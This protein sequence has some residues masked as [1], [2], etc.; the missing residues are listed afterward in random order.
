MP[1]RIIDAFDRT[2]AARAEHPALY[3][4]RN[5][6]W[7]PTTWR[8]YRQ[9]VRLA[10][11]ALIALG[12]EPG[13][14][15]TIIGFNSA[16][17]FIADIGAIAAGAIPAGIYTTNTPDQ[18]Q[19]IAE[20]CEA[21]VAFVENAEQ[22]A[23]FR[24]VRDQLPHLTTIVMM[25]AEPESD[26]GAISWRQFLGLGTGVP[27]EKLE[28]RIAAQKP[29]DTCTL[30]YTSGTT[31]VPKAVMLSHTN[32]VWVTETA[33][34]IVNIK[35]GDVVVS[36][37]PLSHVAEQLF[38]LHN[39]VVLG[40][41]IWFAESLDKLGDALKA[42]RPHHFL[43]VPR[44]WEK[45]QAK[46]E[47]V[48]GKNSPIK[49]KIAKWAREQGLAGG[50][51]DQAGAARPMLYGIADKLVFSK[52]RQNIGLDRART[53]VTGAAP[54]SKRTLDFFLSLGLPISEV[55]GMS[56]TT[57][58]GT[59]SHPGK[60]RTGKAGYVMPGVEMR[61]AEDGEICMRGKHIAKGYF[62]DPQATAE[63]IDTDG[64]LH[65]GDIGELDA[66]GFLQITDRKK[67]LIITAGGENIAPAL[68]EGQIKSIGVVSQ[69]V[70]IGDRRRYLSVLLTLDPEKLPAFATLA[71]SAAKNPQEAAECAR[72]SAYLQRE[73]EG[74]NT[75]LARVQTVKKFAV[76]PTELSIDGGE[77]T[78]TMKIKRK[79]VS[80]KYA[81]V[82][83]SLYTEA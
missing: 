20:H 4:R 77:L 24:A 16:E 35:A 75:R 50:Y 68:V 23:K 64:W 54:I 12:V 27:E 70:V 55:Y 2:A 25:N 36:Y 65:T 9:Q 37:L 3:S 52:V 80:Q 13:H 33:G 48:G 44:V 49:K 72:F 51:A 30:I 83:E 73:I 8:E 40:S 18:C 32:L 11:R 57:A 74:V 47:A 78:P 46:I 29:D 43:A 10:A 71:G 6:R 81:S 59:I 82:I 41:T 79:V 66:D 76:L 42:A 69:A 26:D 56:E 34:Q 15:V 60:Y 53:M 62:K 22:L 17:W 19:Y 21:R 7:E 14:H 1:T 5:G 31:G 28:E 67:E 63:T 58:I 39:N 38:S 61:V 45:M